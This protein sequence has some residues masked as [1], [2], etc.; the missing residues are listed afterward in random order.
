MRHQQQGR[1]NRRVH[2]LAFVAQLASSAALGERAADSLAN[3]LPI[4][5]WQGQLFSL[6]IYQ[7]P[8]LKPSTRG[9][10]A[11]QP[12]FWPSAIRFHRSA[13]LLKP[14]SRV[15]V[16]FPFMPSFLI[17]TRW[18]SLLAGRDLCRVPD[19]ECAPQNYFPLSFALARLCVQS[20]IFRGD[21]A[22]RTW[23]YG[24]GFL[25][26]RLSWASHVVY[27]NPHP[28]SVVR[29]NRWFCDSPCLLF[30]HQKLVCRRNSGPPAF[31]NLSP[32]LEPLDKRHR[33]QNFDGR[34]F[35][36]VF[37]WKG[38]ILWEQLPQPHPHF[39]SWSSYLTEWFGRGYTNPQLSLW[40]V[41]MFASIPIQSSAKSK[42]DGFYSQLHGILPMLQQQ[43]SSTEWAALSH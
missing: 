7:Q 22:R 21:Q 14:C 13:G 16:H 11:V 36:Y 18:K 17:G 25:S 2:S 4:G 43:S 1:S 10:P 8:L 5:S 39:L 41:F 37:Q 30:P 28:G 33:G 12:S 24:W 15:R 9:P 27:G 23:N 32:S 3:D 40:V 31:R 34:V 35:F 29:V 26:A 6:D 42:T 38:I 19:P 20:P